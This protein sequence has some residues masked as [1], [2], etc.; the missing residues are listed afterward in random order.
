[1][2]FVH[3]G[4]ILAAML[5]AGLA[6]PAAASR[7]A[8]PSDAGRIQPFQENPFYWQ[9]KSK[10]ILLLGGTDQDNL[11]NHPKSLEPDGLESHLDLLVSVGGNYVRNTMSHR[12]AGNEFPYARAAD[13]RF[14][15]TRWNEEY[16]KRFDAFLRMTQV[17]DIIVQLE[18]WETWDLYGDHEPQ[19]GWSR[20]P[21]NPA[22]NVNYTAGEARLPTAMSFFPSRE[23]TAHAFFHTVPGLEDNPVVLHYQRAFVD[24]V[25]SYSLDNAHVLYCVNNETGE[26]PAWGEYWVKHIR[27]RATEA[28]RRIEITDM[29]RSEEL[30]SP[31]HRLIQNEPDLYSFIEVSQNNGTR[32][33]GQDHWDPLIA[34]REYIADRPRPANNVKIYGGEGGWGGVDEGVQKFWR[35]LFAGCAAVRFH[36]RFPPAGIGLNPLAQAHL[37]SA[38]MLA[39]EVNVF[40]SEPRNDLLSEREPNE[41][42]CLARPGSS[43]ALYFPGGGAVT[44]DLGHAVGEFRLRWLDVA[45]S[46][47]TAEDTLKGG[48][49][50]RIAAPGQG[51]WTAVVVGAA[52]RDSA[53]R[54]P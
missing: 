34:L 18:I 29:R 10:P 5:A 48:G 35:N 45:N 47:W 7:A 49:Q 6:S 3:Q 24:K 51:H 23:P 16:W 50:V 25:L 36:R 20:H 14:D 52:A 1:M 4:Y 39:G 38:R 12:D 8:L 22:N 44:L 32:R 28:G 15:L 21:F 43:Y 9:Y 11:F 30:A 17:R 31:D 42:Y 13:G 40:A 33:R 19:G 27:H 46:R 41:A 26:P 2:F 54:Q 37:R 53:Q